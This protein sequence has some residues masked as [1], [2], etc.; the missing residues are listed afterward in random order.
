MMNDEYAAQKNNSQC[1]GYTRSYDLERKFHFL[2][3]NN[4]TLLAISLI[5]K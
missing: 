3:S 4:I 1:T 2:C 5:A